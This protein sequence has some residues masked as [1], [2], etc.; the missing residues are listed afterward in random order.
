MISTFFQCFSMDCDIQYNT[1][2]LGQLKNLGNPRGVIIRALDCGIVVNEFELQWRYYV[3]I[4]MYTLREGINPP[5]YGL[6]ATIAVHINMFIDYESFI[7]V[8]VEIYEPVCFA[9]L[10]VWFY[11]ISI[12]V[13]YLMVNL[14]Y[15]YI[16]M[17]CKYKSIKLNSSKYCN[18]SRT[19]VICSM[20]NSSYFKLYNL[21]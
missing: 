16:Y 8:F 17:I 6:N 13:S 15:S 7:N 14:L 12:I 9:L 5:L 11:G 18:A 3:Y 1:F 2:G 10:L 19:S 20:M 21:A 4:Q